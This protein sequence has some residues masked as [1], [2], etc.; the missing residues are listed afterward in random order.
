M[1]E[2]MKGLKRT[3]RCGELSTANIGETVT[4]MGWVQKQRN[5]GGIIFVDLRDR[6]GILQVIFEESECGAENFAKAE[7]LRS[8]FVVAVVGKVT[9]RE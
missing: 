3:C 7:K 8:E 5:K 6:A 9:K 1:A 4:V 2:S